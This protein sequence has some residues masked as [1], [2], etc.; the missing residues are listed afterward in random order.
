MQGNALK[1]DKLITSTVGEL[2][3]DGMQDH[4]DELV[5]RVELSSRDE[6]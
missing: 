3:E 2:L 4:N 6:T 5:F 1:F